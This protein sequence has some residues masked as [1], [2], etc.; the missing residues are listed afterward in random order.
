MNK[1]NQTVLSGESTPNIIS[2]RVVRSGEIFFIAF[3]SIV[4][5]TW[6]MYFDMENTSERKEFLAQRK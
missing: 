1:V 3:D 5:P 4:A 6:I 2:G